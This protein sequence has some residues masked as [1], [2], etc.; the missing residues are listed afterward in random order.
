LLE[1]ESYPRAEYWD[2]LAA[3]S[4]T[5]VLYTADEPEM[6][7]FQC[8]DGSHLSG[9]DQIAFTQALLKWHKSNDLVV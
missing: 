5:P 3:R 6:A 1:A 7:S 4:A 8:P 9:H 2:K